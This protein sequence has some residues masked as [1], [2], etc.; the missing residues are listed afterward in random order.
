LERLADLGI[1]AAAGSF[2]GAAGARHVRIA[3]TA[4]DAQIEAAAQR[5]AGSAHG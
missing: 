1:L 4:T 2:Y 3:L 5:L